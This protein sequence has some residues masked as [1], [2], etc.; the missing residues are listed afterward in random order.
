MASFCI[1]CSKKLGLFSGGNENIFSGDPAVKI[2]DECL[3]KAETI[4][5]KVEMKIPVEAE[6]YDRFTAE[7]IAYINEFLEPDGLTIGGG[8]DAKHTVS[9]MERE[10]GEA[11]IDRTFQVDDEE[12]QQILTKLNSMS[13]EEIENF[14][15]G[16]VSEN[17][18]SEG[19]M[20]DIKALNDEELNAVIS[21]QREYFNNA[22]WAYIMYVYNFRNKIEAEPTTEDIQPIPLPENE[23][24]TNE[25]E[26]LLGIFSE[27]TQEELKEIV[28]DESYTP[29]ARQA[30]KALLSE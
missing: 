25:V 20:N 16:L 27:K 10:V 14:L 17:D 23:L 12:A 8:A 5:K 28:N 1:L 22:E 13:S 7:G 30:A 21:E 6:D 15:E 29:E 9:P 24:D 26:R 18:T 3:K 19:F 2:C 4:L 11:I